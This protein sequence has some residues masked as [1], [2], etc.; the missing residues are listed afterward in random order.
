MFCVS[1]I[2][3]GIQPGFKKLPCKVPFNWTFFLSS[4]IKKNHLVQALINADVYVC[5][6]QIMWVDRLKTNYMN[7]TWKVF[8][9]CLCFS[10]AHYFGCS[11]F[12]CLFLPLPLSFS[13]TSP[14]SL[15]CSLCFCSWLRFSQTKPKGTTLKLWRTVAPSLESFLQRVWL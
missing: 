13:L 5:A 9:S 3:P 15:C 2:K 8:S 1:G 14:I 7:K 4:C 6:R 12:L 10:N 11:L